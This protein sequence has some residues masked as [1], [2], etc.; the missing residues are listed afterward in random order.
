MKRR[1]I[2]IYLLFILW[3]HVL[4][5]GDFENCQPDM[6]MPGQCEC[7]VKG[8]PGGV[9]F[10]QCSEVACSEFDP[11]HLPS[12]C[13]GDVKRVT[14]LLTNPNLAPGCTLKFNRVAGDENGKLLCDMAVYHINRT[15]PG[16][17]YYKYL[18]FFFCT[19][20]GHSQPIHYG[21]GLLD[22]EED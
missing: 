16:S 15:G 10:P 17:R 5:A 14:C 13:E 1:T 21:Y 7:D 12:D 6:G 18:D 4:L 3:S 19:P 2:F 11:R 22:V 9:A 8:S 20:A